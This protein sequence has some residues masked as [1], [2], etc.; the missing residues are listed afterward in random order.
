M[1]TGRDDSKRPTRADKLRAVLDRFVSDLE[2]WAGDDE[3]TWEAINRF[4]REGRAA[5][6]EQT[7]VECDEQLRRTAGGST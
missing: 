5:L 4:A 1:S 2:Y 6:D 7:I 3:S